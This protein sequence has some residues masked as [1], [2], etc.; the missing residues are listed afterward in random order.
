[1]NPRIRLPLVVFALITAF[2]TADLFGE[3]VDYSEVSLLVRARDSEASITREVSHRKLVR[4]LTPQQETTLKAQGASDSLIQ[5]LRRSDIA[6][7]PADAT[8]FETRREQS[9][10]AKKSALATSDENNGDRDSTNVHVF[11]VAFGHPINLSQWG[12]LDYEIAFYSYRFAGEDQIEPVMVDN[13][14]TVTEVTHPIRFTTEDEAFSRDFFLTNAVR[15]QRYKP[16]EARI[17]NRDTRLE[18]NET[19]SV[20]SNTASRRLTIDW[21]NPVYMHGQPYA[22]YPVYGAGD[23]SLYYIGK[24][25]DRT[26]RVAI[27]SRR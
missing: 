16:Y 24:A 6:L 11:N 12:G 1:M 25:N 18:Q 9:R 2:S 17:D 5:T 8:A 7:A 10:Q 21:Q 14:R 26:A 19:V 3:P 23:A 15:N 13:L 27:V 4:A 22:F 20:R